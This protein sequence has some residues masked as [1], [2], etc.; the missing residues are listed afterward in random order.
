MGAD[1][2]KIAGS[3]PQAPAPIAGESGE[4]KSY[5]DVAGEIFVVPACGFAAEAD[6]IL[7]RGLSGEI[8][9]DIAAGFQIG[10]RVGCSDAAFGAAEHHFLCPPPG[11]PEGPMRA[12]HVRDCVRRHPRG[13]AA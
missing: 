12:G 11:G 9:S 4:G 5:G 3:Y 7:A 6:G 8:I 10:W 1:L 13:R 2:S